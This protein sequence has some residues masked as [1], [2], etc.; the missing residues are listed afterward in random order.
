[1]DVDAVAR[2][3]ASLLAERKKAEASLLAI[4]GAVE[5]CKYWLSKVEGVEDE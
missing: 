3:L 1:M 5:E 2:R 4:S